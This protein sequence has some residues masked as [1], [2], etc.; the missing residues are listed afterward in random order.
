M[1]ANPFVS[2]FI[3]TAPVGATQAGFGV[4]A[5]LSYNASDV[6]GSDIGRIYG[7]VDGIL[8]DGF[9][10]DGPEALWGA[11]VF[12]QR[13]RPPVVVIFKGALPP[14]MRYQIGAN[15]VTAGRD[16]RG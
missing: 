7:G 2:T 6:F 15:S 11:A 5:L 14:T 3:S 1:V 8:D 13:R 12:G 16:L 4:P 9:A 10:A